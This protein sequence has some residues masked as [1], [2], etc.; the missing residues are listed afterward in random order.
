[1]RHKDKKNRGSVL[2]LVAV[3]LTVLMGFVALAV[4]VGRLATAKVQCQNAADAAAIAGRERS[5]AAPT[6]T[7]APRPQTPLPWPHLGKFSVHSSAR[8]KFPCSTAHTITTTHPRPST[9][10]S[11]LWRG[12]LQPQS[13]YH[14]PSSVGYILR[15]SRLD[16]YDRHGDVNGSPPAAGCC[17][18][19]GLFRVDEQRKRSVER[20][21]L[22][23]RHGQHP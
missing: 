17:H 12:Q 18:R 15:S 5:M 1:M 4:D 20:G 22:P 14:C 3:C 13:G 9:R 16:F 8:P 6:P 2:A 11:R 10:S 23:R 7:S 19:P 21:K